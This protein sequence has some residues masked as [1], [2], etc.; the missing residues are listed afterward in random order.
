M[1]LRPSWERDCLL[2]AVIGV[3]ARNGKY[4]VNGILP[5]SC[6]D[7]VSNLLRLEAAIARELQCPGVLRDRPH[8]GVR[9]PF[10]HVRLDFQCDAHR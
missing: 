4:S 8:D 7:S 5:L 1:L 3:R 2:N 9:S 6:M 10:G